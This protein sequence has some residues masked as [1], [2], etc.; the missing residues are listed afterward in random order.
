MTLSKK[1]RV[2]LIFEIS[3]NLEAEPN[4]ERMNIILNTFGLGSV[5]D[6]LDGPW[7]ME[8]LNSGSDETMED[9]AEYFDIDFQ[10]ADIPMQEQ[11][12]KP[13]S[14]LFV[15]ASHLYKHKLFIHEVKKDL[16]RY[17]IELF[18]AHDSITV[19]SNWQDEIEKALDRADAGLAFLHDGFKDSAWCD[20]EV[21]WLLGRHVPVMALHFGTPPYGPLGKHQAQNACNSK[22]QD[23]VD[24]IVKRIS[25]KDILVPS[26]TESLIT[27]LFNSGS[28]NTTDRIWR[29]LKKVT[30]LDCRQCSKILHACQNNSQ[31]YGAY[32]FQDERDYPEVILDFLKKQPGYPEIKQDAES[33]S[34]QLETS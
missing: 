1:E 12:P 10:S 29:H 34:Q 7:V 19:D 4:L 18:V 26:L 6:S 33:Y 15:F 3:E 16:A 2:R 31:I 8:L 28:Y 20:Q 21:G 13:A 5:D 14:N 11:A 17:G 9:L 24:D 23:L 30:D 22:A 27:G 32:S 25:A